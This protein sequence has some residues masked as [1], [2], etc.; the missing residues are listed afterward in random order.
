MP[1]HKLLSLKV[2]HVAKIFIQL[3]AC[4]AKFANQK[5]IIYA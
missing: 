5:S 2:M 3:H 4:F 1:T